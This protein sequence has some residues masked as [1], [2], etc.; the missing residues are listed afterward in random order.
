M[1]G[2]KHTIRIVKSAFRNATR[3]QIKRV[4]KGMDGYQDNEIHEQFVTTYGEMTLKGI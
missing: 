1:P 2:K 3:K 4:Y